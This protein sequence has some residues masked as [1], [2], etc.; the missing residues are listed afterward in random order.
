MPIK[1][2]VIGFTDYCAK[3]PKPGSRRLKLAKKLTWKFPKIWLTVTRKLTGSEKSISSCQKILK[4]RW[5]VSEPVDYL[6]ECKICLETHWKRYRRKKPIWQHWNLIQRSKSEETWL[7]L[8]GR[9][10]K[11][12]LKKNSSKKLTAKALAGYHLSFLKLVSVGLRTTPT[13]QKMPQISSNNHLELI[14]GDLS[15]WVF[16][17]GS[18]INALIPRER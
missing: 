2:R 16:P 11:L 5:V 8:L 7:E 1:H 12:Q 10:G 15:D 6:Q 18:S 4:I 9:P 3:L 13:K 14:H 17:L